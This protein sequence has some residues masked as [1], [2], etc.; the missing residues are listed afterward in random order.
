MNRYRQLQP[1]IQQQPI[2]PI[3]QIILNTINGLNGKT[4]FIYSV[5]PELLDIFSVF[6]DYN[7]FKVNHYRTL[8]S[9]T[10]NKKI[11]WELF[12]EMLG[13]THIQRIQYRFFFNDKIPLLI[14]Y[15]IYRYNIN[16]YSVSM[17]PD[18]LNLEYYRT[19]NFDI[20]RL[21]DIDLLSH[22]EHNGKYEPRLFKL[23]NVRYELSQLII[24]TT[25]D[26]ILPEF[27]FEIE[28]VVTKEL[29]VSDLC[30]HQLIQGEKGDKGDKGDKGIKGDIGPRG[31]NGAKGDR[32]DIGPKGEK[33]EP[34][35]K[36]ERGGLGEQGYKGEKGVKGDKGDKGER[37]DRGEKG[38][39]GEHGERGETGERGSKGDKGD[40]GPIGF[41][42]EQG[43]K[44]IKGDNGEKGERGETGERGIGL[45]IDEYGTG[46]PNKTSVP[47]GYTFVDC[48]KLLMY[49]KKPNGDWS[50]GLQ[51][52]TVVVVK[53]K[54]CPTIECL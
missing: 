8:M 44:G 20:Q 34:G 6:F 50:P 22:W 40:K 37:G 33:G 52:N 27:S 30:N 2:L 23:N 17:N 53:C 45:K 15:F 48:D 12:K 47:I 16:N 39:I 7:L 10:I 38:E 28:K 26:I 41:K 43:D 32:G 29:P 21:S 4:G 3:L 42:G 31:D 35:P 49:I 9:S 18:N 19:N 11:L 14:Q 46:P 5:N 51:L 36:G 1:Q 13:T 25:T 54:H 24:P